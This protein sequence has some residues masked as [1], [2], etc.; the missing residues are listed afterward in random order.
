MAKTVYEVVLGEGRSAAFRKMG[1]R[2]L[3][4]AFAKAGEPAG[5]DLAQNY[6]TKLAALELCVVEAH[7]K[8]V[9]YTDL[10]TGW[11]DHFDM[12][13]TQLL[14]HAWGKIHEP[15]AAGVALGKP[16]ERSGG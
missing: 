14:M 8:P 6:A 1:A 16:A 7:G 9:T 4:T 12:A 13:E 10:T 2:E 3:L 11:D 5:G 15:S